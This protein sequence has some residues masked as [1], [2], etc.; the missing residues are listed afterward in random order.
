[1]RVP[2]GVPRQRGLV[3]GRLERGAPEDGRVRQAEGLQVVGGGGWVAGDA[4]APLL[5]LL[6]L[7]VVML[8]LLLLVVA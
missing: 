2:V 3:E 6:L 5:V 4:A 8:L 1:V 7:V